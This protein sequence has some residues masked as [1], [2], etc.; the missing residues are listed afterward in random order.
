MRALAIAARGCSKSRMIFLRRVNARVRGIDSAIWK[1]FAPSSELTAAL[2][3]TV[4]TR[5]DLPLQKRYAF[6]F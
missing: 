6:E 5:S 1:V 4:R 2:A 3:D